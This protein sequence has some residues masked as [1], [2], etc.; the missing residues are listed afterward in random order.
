M[1]FR[2]SNESAGRRQWSRAEV[3]AECEGGPGG[4]GKETPD[5]TLGD[6]HALMWR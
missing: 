2:E 4:R 5:T 1:A 6:V 3:R